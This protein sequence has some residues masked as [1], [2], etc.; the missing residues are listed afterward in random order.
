MA[1]NK[2]LWDV[3]LGG[4]FIRIPLGLY[5]LLA[6]R[7]KLEHIEG[8]I[9]TV[10]TFGILPDQAA[11]L[12]GVMLPWMEVIIGFLLIVGFW[13]SAV[14]IVSSLMLFS[15]IVAVGIFPMH[16]DIFNK[17]I[18]LLCASLALLATGSGAF[19]VDSFRRSG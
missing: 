19:S 6:G 16:P 5:F 4:M 2:P 7:M 18:I 8:F 11:V 17:D 1:V 13:T 15:F 14:A 3:N 9:E 12:Y 10:R